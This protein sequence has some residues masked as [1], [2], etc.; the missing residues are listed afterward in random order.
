MLS[1]GG[2]EFCI[3]ST[4]MFII[5]SPILLLESPLM[6]SPR[7][8]SLCFNLLADKRRGFPFSSVGVPSLE[9]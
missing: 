5:L 6:V 7:C 9:A 2:G 3:E 4:Y 8:S 1:F